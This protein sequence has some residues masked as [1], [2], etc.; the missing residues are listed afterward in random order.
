[1]AAG[2]K[3][4]SYYDGLIIGTDNMEIGRGWL[5]LKLQITKKGVSFGQILNA[6]GETHF[7]SILYPLELFVIS[8]IVICYLFVICIL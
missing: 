4:K 2:L 3:I 5:E 7:G 1:V 6:F 8:D